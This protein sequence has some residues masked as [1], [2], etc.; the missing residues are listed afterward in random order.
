MG[1]EVWFI[2][3]NRCVSMYSTY[4]WLHSIRRRSLPHISLLQGVR[5]QKWAKGPN[6]H[7][8]RTY[9]L[10]WCTHDLGPVGVHAGIHIG[11]YKHTKT[12]YSSVFQ[13]MIGKLHAGARVTETHT[14]GLL[15][16][17]MHHR[18]IMRDYGRVC[19]HWKPFLSC[20]R[21]KLTFTCIHWPLVWF[22]VVRRTTLC[23]RIVKFLKIFMLF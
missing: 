13:K 21:G 20:L 15:H 12:L 4:T 11:T 23:I 6:S 16:S 3:D 14:A 19:L 17:V 1:T 10:S 2:R 5:T 22:H 8:L 18:N 9:F 7:P